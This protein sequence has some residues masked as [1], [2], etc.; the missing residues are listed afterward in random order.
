MLLS[1]EGEADLQGAETLLRGRIERFFHALKQGTRIGDRRL[2]HADDLRKR[3]AFDAAAFRA[4]DTA[5]LARNLL[6]E[7]AG[8]ASRA[9]GHRRAHASGPLLRA[10]GASRTADGRRLPRQP[11]PAIARH[12][13]TAGRP[14]HPRHLRAGDTGLQGRPDGE[15]RI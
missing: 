7:P 15:R 10:Q 13:E 8:L 1:T 9:A 2:D 3:I 14:D 4:W 6:G 12:Y 11:A 5:W